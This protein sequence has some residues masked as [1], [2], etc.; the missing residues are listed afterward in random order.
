MTPFLYRI[1]ETYYKENSGNLSDIA[2]VFPNRRAGVF[3]QKYIAQ[4]AQKPIFSPPI[5]TISDLFCQF[6][7]YLQADRTSMLF[8]LYQK[9][10]ALSL[11]NESFDDFVFWGYVTQRFR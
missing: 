6:S 7:P 3:F 11:S 1:A 4:V 5:L 10:Q 9:F 8:I 2:F